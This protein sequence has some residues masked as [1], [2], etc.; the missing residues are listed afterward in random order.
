[1][2]M[3]VTVHS[4]VTLILLLG[5]ASAHGEAPARLR[6]ALLPL[7]Q[8]NVTSAQAQR[9]ERT[10]RRTLGRRTNLTILD[11]SA[12]AASSQPASQPADLR[13]VGQRLGADKLLRL[14]V[15]QL[16][17]TTI[18]RLTAFDVAKGARQGSW[19]EVLR[20]PGDEAVASAVERMVA[21]FAP[22][23]PPDSPWYKRWWVW[24]A[25]GVVVAGTVTAILVTTLNSEPGPDH[26]VTP[27]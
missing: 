3:R 14:R 27:P 23:P 20:S 4:V 17:D 15:G 21:S 11:A 10:L 9:Y 22:L 8:V 16:G 19:Q 12:G 24:T 25:A 2:P 13:R 7:E 5:A 26:T 1:M 18:I 6:V